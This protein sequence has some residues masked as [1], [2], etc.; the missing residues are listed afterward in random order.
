[1]KGVAIYPRSWSTSACR[2][3]RQS[4]S[5]PALWSVNPGRA[6][7]SVFFSKEFISAPHVVIGASRRQYALPAT[8]FNLSTHYLFS[9]AL[10]RTGAQ[11]KFKILRKFC[12]LP[13]T[14]LESVGFWNLGT[15]TLRSAIALRRLFSLP[16]LCRVT[17]NSSFFDPAAFQALWG[18][19]SPHIKHLRLG[20]YSPVGRSFLRPNTG[21]VALSSLKLESSND[22]AEWLNHDFC[23]FD[24]SQL[25]ALSVTAHHTLVV[26]QPR[27]RAAHRTI[28]VLEFDIGVLFDGTCI[29]LSQFSNL[30]FLRINIYAFQQA[31]TIALDTLATITSSSPIRRI[32]LSI[33]PA[34]NV[35]A[36]MCDLLDSKVAGLPLQHLSAVELETN[37]EYYN[38][39]ASYFPRLRSQNLLSG[40]TDPGWFERHSSRFR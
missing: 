37:I 5:Q 2:M 12:N 32:V 13:F 38:R 9:E 31:M 16:T 36:D 29:D 10:T 35:E 14:H 18:T 6:R 39:L 25:A 28:E 20:C 24:F 23:P 30:Q 21:P 7:R 11:S 17:L 27:M 4:T 33:L 15:T 22:V 34:Y 8:S 3:S 19:C 1:M 40:P 26:G